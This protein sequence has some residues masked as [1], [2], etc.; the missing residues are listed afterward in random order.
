MKTKKIIGC[1][2]SAIY[3]TKY[4]LQK[5]YPVNVFNS[6][7]SNVEINPVKPDVLTERLDKLKSIKKIKIGIGGSFNVKYKGQKN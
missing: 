3:V 2:S 6:Y 4:F 1:S 7:A 5:R